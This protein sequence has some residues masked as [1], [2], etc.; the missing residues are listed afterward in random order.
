ME[1]GGL[2]LPP[3]QPEGET[4][5]CIYIWHGRTCPYGE[6]CNRNHDF[7]ERA[8]SSEKPAAAAAA[9][10]GTGGSAV[11]AELESQRKS[12]RALT[13]SIAELTTKMSSI[14][15]SVGGVQREQGAAMAQRRQQRQQAAAAGAELE[16][17]KP[18]KGTMFSIE[19][20]DD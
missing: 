1:P 15:E 18:Q 20:E 12:I 13:D 14:V 7:Q 16:T 2:T 19:E 8:Q 9:G 3:R 4:P 6:R 11:Q 17:L 10:E 5:W